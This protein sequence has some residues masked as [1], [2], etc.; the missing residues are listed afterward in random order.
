[1]DSKLYI[2]IFILLN[3][4]ICFSK[5]PVVG[6]F[7]IPS[8]EEGYDSKEWSYIGGSYIKYLENAG[9]IV[10][11][12]KYDYDTK[13]LDYLLDRINGILFP[14]GDPSLWEN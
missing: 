14:G 9:A 8:L 7:L 11:P 2:A 10:V 12:I 1:M 4:S 3:F 5:R 13:T 6:V